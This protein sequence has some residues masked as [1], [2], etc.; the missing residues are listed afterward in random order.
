M[1]KKIECPIDNY[2]SDWNLYWEQNP[3]IHRSVGAAG[4][5]GDGDGG[6]DEA[7]KKAAEE[8]ANAEKLANYDN[9]TAQ[10]EEQKAELEKFKAKHAEAEKHR[11]EQEQAARKAAEEAAKK[12]GDVEALEK[13]WSEK[14][15]ASEAAHAESEATYKG[16][17]NDL[18]VG[19]AAT[20]MAAELA[21]DGSAEV[22]IPHIKSRL[23][24][25][26][27]DGKP[28]VKVTVDGKPSALSLDDLK[29]EISESK[30]FA[31]I[32][33]GSNSSGGGVNTGQGKGGAKTMKRSDFDTLSPIQQSHF[34]RNEKGTVVDG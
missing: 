14:L 16:M 25:E 30:A 31:P 18:T 6:D 15:S 19:A 9:I 4:D 26:L 8:K 7:A 20:T 5:G 2:S 22:L 23:T 28:T 3:H 29:K 17:I 12:S 32:I 34:I 27:R 1:K 24:M 33:K 10:M 11:K 13:S 21:L